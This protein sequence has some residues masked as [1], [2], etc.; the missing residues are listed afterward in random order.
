MSAIVLLR[1]RPRGRISLG[2][3]LAAGAGS[4][5]RPSSASWCSS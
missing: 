5:H 3:R 1:P 4:G 2:H